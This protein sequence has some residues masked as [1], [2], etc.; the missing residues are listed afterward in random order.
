MH[1]N[2]KRILCILA[3]ALT[4]HAEDAKPLLDCS[5]G[6]WATDKACIGATI[7]DLQKQIDALQTRVAEQQKEI[8]AKDQQ[9]ANLQRLLVESQRDTMAY[10]AS[11]NACMDHLPQRPMEKK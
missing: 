2:T 7:P 6:K 9:N 3:L 8:A 1:I 5:N 10:R 4:L 11:L